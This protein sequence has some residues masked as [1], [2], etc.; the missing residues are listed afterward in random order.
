[1]E[2]D[3]EDLRVNVPVS[4]LESSLDSGPDLVGLSNVTQHV[5]IELEP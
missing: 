3:G 2:F 5:S 1:M 4:S